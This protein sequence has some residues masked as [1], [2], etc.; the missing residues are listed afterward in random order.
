MTSSPRPELLAVEEAV[1]AVV[2]RDEDRL[3]APGSGSRR[4]PMLAGAILDLHVL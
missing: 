3:R 2:D 1:R 4:R